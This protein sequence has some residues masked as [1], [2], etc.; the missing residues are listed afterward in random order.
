MLGFDGGSV[1]PSRQLPRISTDFNNATL[2]SADPSTLP[3]S[4]P[5]LHLPTRAVPST[6]WGPANVGGGSLT[7]HGEIC[8]SH[9]QSPPQYARSLRLRSRSTS[10]ISDREVDG[11]ER[12]RRSCFVVPPDWPPRLPPPHLLL[13]LISAFFDN[14][15]LAPRILHRPKFTRAIKA[16][17]RLSSDH[18]TDSFS[19]SR[20][21]VPPTHGDLPPM[22]SI[23]L[24]HAICAFGVS[25]VSLCTLA[26]LFR[27]SF[28]DLED[29]G[30]RAEVVAAFGIEHC[31]HAKFLVNDDVVHSRRLLECVQTTVIMGW[32]SVSHY[33]ICFPPFSSSLSHV[34]V[35]FITHSIRST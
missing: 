14:H 35:P 3:F 33:P 26:Q 23:A 24:L 15:V 6:S 10:P 8:K 31:G 1:P 20:S 13:D 9:L 18:G 22:P 29:P 7:N 28:P 11:R 4:R 30:L 17:A 34:L 12:Y 2:P 16:R 21:A 27:R 32:Y 19:Y 25:F 5:R